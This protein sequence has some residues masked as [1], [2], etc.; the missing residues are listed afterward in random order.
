MIGFENWTDDVGDFAIMFLAD[1]KIF[2]HKFGSMRF[3]VDM[4]QDLSHVVYVSEAT[5]LF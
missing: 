1:Q 5:E 2:V 3:L 4:T